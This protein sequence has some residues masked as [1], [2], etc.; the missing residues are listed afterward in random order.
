[1]SIRGIVQQFTEAAVIVIHSEGRLTA[2]H[3]NLTGGGKDER[4]EGQIFVLLDATVIG[5][6]PRRI[7]VWC[8]RFGQEVQ[9]IGPGPQSDHWALHQSGTRCNRSKPCVL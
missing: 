4:R 2:D 5:A 7:W 9:A 1:M 3:S 6:V 8:H